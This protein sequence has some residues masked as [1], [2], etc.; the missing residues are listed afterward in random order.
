MEF[1]YF[2]AT[3]LTI[4]FNHLGALLFG[5]MITSLFNRILDIFGQWVFIFLTG[6]FWLLL[7][8]GY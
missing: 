8:N 3:W 1:G 2:L 4:L 6:I 7:V 5:K